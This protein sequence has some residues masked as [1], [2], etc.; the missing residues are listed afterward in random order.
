MISDKRKFKKDP[1]AEAM[2]R[3]LVGMLDAWECEPYRRLSAW[4]FLFRRFYVITRIDMGR[5]LKH[6]VR[7]YAQQ[8]VVM[9]KCDD[10]LESMR[11]GLE[12]LKP[13]TMV[14]DVPDVDTSLLYEKRQAL[15]IE[16]LNTV[17]RQAEQV[18][19][20]KAGGD[21]ARMM[22]MWYMTI[23]RTCMLLK[24]RN[25]VRSNDSGTSRSKDK[26]PSLKQHNDSKSRS[27]DFLCFLADGG[28]EG[29]LLDAA[30][31]VGADKRPAEAKEM[32]E[33]NQETAK[34]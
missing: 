1:K 5:R 25:L 2:Y 4:S 27:K 20:A 15:G 6:G 29:V 17:Y 11:I 9:G 19:N 22:S 7:D 18:L 8:I 12:L 24:H 3:E 21:T 33:A 10:A 34:E 28:L 13:K 31:Q 14:P 32:H 23:G 16:R 26:R 30:K